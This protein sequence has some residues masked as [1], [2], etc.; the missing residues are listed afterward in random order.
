MLEKVI[1][2]GSRE[3]LADGQI[4]VR[5][6]THILEDDVLVSVSYHREVISPGQ[7]VSNQPEEVKR[8]AKLEH[9]DEVIK[10][11]IEARIG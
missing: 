7:D 8:L 1:K 4:Q 10:A 3:I 11:Y 2:I 5:H 6:D 9:T